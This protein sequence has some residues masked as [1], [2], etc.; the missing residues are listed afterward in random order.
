MVEA[1]LARV[2]EKLGLNPNSSFR[3]DCFDLSLLT[4][5]AR[6][7]FK[8]LHGPRLQNDTIRLVRRNFNTFVR[9]SNDGKLVSPVLRK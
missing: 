8:D 9:Q 5:A 7:D 6:T 2:V 3:H 4:P 1:L